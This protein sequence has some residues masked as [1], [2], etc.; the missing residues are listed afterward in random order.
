LSPVLWT[1][2]TRRA[3]VAPPTKGENI[4]A[5]ADDFQNLIMPGVTHWQHP[6]FFAYFPAAGTLESIIG[7][8]YASTAMN[9][10]FNVRA[11]PVSS[12]H[13]TNTSGAQWMCSPA[14]TELETIVMD[15]AAQLYGLSKDFHNSTHVGGGVI[16]VGQ[17][18]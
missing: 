18:T 6:S 8:L 10:G 15:W 14:C 7:D 16:Q 12:G 5:I 2:L 13:E 17:T 3:S 11:F 9:P 1:A 4:D